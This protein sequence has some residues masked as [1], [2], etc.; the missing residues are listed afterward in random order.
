M[1]RT[2]LQR[3]LLGSFG[4]VETSLSFFI[5]SLSA[6]CEEGCVHGQCQQPGKCLCASGY[7]GPRCDQ[8][9]PMEGCVHGSCSTPFGCDCEPGWEGTNCNTSTPLCDRMKPCLNGGQ[10]HPF[11]EH[12]FVCQCPP[13]FTGATCAIALSPC[14]G[15]ANPCANGATCQHIGVFDF[16]CRCAKGWTGRFC[17]RLDSRQCQNGG[18][19]T[20]EGSCL[21]PSGF[22]GTS[23]ELAVLTNS[24]ESNQ[25]QRISITLSLVVV[26]VLVILV[27][28]VFSF[29]KNEK[30]DR[31]VVYSTKF[32]KVSITTDNVYG[33]DPSDRTA[34]KRL[35]EAEAKFTAKAASKAPSDEHIYV[36]IDQDPKDGDQQFLEGEQPLKSLLSL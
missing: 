20:E 26:L 7:E 27:L 29:P 1:D 25:L 11:G 19:R 16:L 32:K 28:I 6:I 5:V 18:V 22:E 17:D 10:C 31:G 34:T 36:D 2:V 21:C 8:C 3:T 23:C 12:S 9:I 30:E 15:E 35:L 13:G 33:S 14:A 24:G 4:G